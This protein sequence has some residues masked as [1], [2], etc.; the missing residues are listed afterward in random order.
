M[1]A[2]DNVNAGMIREPFPDRP[3]L[4][5]GQEVDDPSAFKVADDRAVALAFVLRPSRRFPRPA[6]MR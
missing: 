5:V 6:A 1:V 3:I 2:A 4:M